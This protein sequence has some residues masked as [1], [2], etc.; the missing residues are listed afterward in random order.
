VLDVS[1]WSKDLAVD[2]GGSDVINHAGA[3]TL[4]LLADRT[5][6]T[7]GLS[8]ALARRGFVP[9]HCRG[10]VLA[11]TA[12]VIADGGQV[13][14]DL[15][16]RAIRASC[17]GRWLRTRRCGGCWSKSASRSAARSL[18]RGPRLVSTCGH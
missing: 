9:V 4:R 14:S 1:S 17:M 3:A 12:V 10:R 8:R 13:L 7:V 5:G 11:D 15:A 18:G 2:V 6:L 16:M